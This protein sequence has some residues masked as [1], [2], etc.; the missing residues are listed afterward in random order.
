[1]RSERSSTAS[2]NLQP[3]L[4]NVD[5]IDLREDFRGG[6]ARAGEACRASRGYQQ[7]R[8]HLTRDEDFASDEVQANRIAWAIAHGHEP[9]APS[10]HL[11][12][13]LNGPGRF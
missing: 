10:S 6:I 9:P 5:A 2:G 4:D 3:D 1:M 11:P 8:T 13:L 7:R 12:D